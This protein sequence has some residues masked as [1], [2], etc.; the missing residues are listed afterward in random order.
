MKMQIIGRR[1]TQTHTKILT[2]TFIKVK[3][4]KRKKRKTYVPYITQ[5]KNKTIPYSIIE[6][7]LI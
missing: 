4:E 5:K 6:N 1:R 7:G 2:K 3:K